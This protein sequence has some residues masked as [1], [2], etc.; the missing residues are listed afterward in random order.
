LRTIG[1]S[2]NKNWIRTGT[3]KI[4][5]IMYV[6]SIEKEK[7]KEK[8]ERKRNYCGESVVE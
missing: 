6:R 3:I 1:W 8:I 4:S 5:E 2:R 7:K